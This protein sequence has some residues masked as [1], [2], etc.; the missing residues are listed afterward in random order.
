[1]VELV[2]TH[3][4]GTCA[5]R[6]VGSSPTERTNIDCSADKYSLSAVESIIMRTCRNWHTG[7]SKKPNFVGS[8]PT[9]RTNALMLKNSVEGQ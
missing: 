5:E 7:W 6:C 3:V 8:T 2:D 9:V 4:L 1:M